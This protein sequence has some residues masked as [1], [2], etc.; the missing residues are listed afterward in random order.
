[1][2]R[3]P[4]LHQDR[5]SAACRRTAAIAAM[6]AAGLA[7]IRHGPKVSKAFVA[8]VGH[9]PA[10]ATI[11][12][13]DHNRGYEPGNVQWMTRRQQDHPNQTEPP[14]R[15]DSVQLLLPLEGLAFSQPLL[16]RLGQHR[17][18]RVRILRPP[19]MALAKQ[20]NQ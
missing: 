13:L 16:C 14:L 15:F 18:K 11:G 8:A 19:G 6:A 10:G 5:K 4:R 7:S 12:R 9:Q 17:P 3:A 20:S 2:P 1:M